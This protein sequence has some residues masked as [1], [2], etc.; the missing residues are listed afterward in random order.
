MPRCDRD[1]R[2]AHLLC[3]R[4]REQ[5]DGAGAEHRDGLAEAQVDEPEAVHT[6]GQRLDERAQLEVDLVRQRVE[7]VV[8]DR[9]V[10]G[11]AARLAEAVQLPRRAQVVVP[12]AALGASHADVEQLQRHAIALLKGCH[13]VAERRHFARNL[14]TRHRAGAHRKLATIEVQVAAADAGVAHADEHFAGAGV[15]DV[16]V[17]D[18]ERLRAGVYGLSHAPLLSKALANVARAHRR[19]HGRVKALNQ[20]QSWWGWHGYNHPEAMSITEIMR[21]G[22][23]TPRVTALLWLGMERGASIILAADPPGAG[24]TT[25]LTALLA[26]TRPDASVYFTRGWGRPSA[27]HR[28]PKATRPCTC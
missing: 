2:G 27:C 26:F 23:I 6:D 8:R 11:E 20:P 9:D 4:R 21:A 25:I 28:A 15:A 7:R 17:L 1:V 16:A 12:R 10:L 13:A 5:P 24:K 19:Y 18:L 3:R 14:V 22:T